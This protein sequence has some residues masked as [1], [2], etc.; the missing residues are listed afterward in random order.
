MPKTDNS[1]GK[2]NEIQEKLNEFMEKPR[3]SVII[4]QNDKRFE[5]FNDLIE[6]IIKT[7]RRASKK[8]KRK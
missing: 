7:F 1:K 6:E 8:R 4:K 3:N 2:I 5:E